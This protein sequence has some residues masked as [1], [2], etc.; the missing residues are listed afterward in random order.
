[1]TRLEAIEKYLDRFT[2]PL[3]E[4]WEKGKSATGEDFSIWL[5]KVALPKMRNLIGDIHDD[6]AQ[7][8][9]PNG[10]RNGAVTPQPQRK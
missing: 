6:V 9:E 2:G 3:I 7:A 10:I 5:R 1:M 8:T 4:G